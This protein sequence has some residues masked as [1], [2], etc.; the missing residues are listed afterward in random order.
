M[1]NNEELIRTIRATLDRERP[2]ST[3]EAQKIIERLQTAHNRRKIES[4]DGLSPEQ[5]AGFLYMPFECP[6]FVTFALQL[7]AYA[8]APILELYGRIANA[9][10][11][12]GLKTTVKGNLPRALVREAAFACFPEDPD[13][14]RHVFS[15]EDFP[16][17]HGVRLMT[18]LA[19]LIRKQHGKF[20]LTAKARK[21]HA[22]GGVASSFAE[23]FRTF[24]KQFHWGYWD[25]LPEL[26]IVQDAFMFSL[27]LFAR[28]GAEPR[29]ESFYSDAFL[30]AFPLAIREAVE[31]PW[32]TPEETVRMTY[33]IRTFRFM[34]L[35]GFAERLD[36]Q[37]E[38]QRRLYSPTRV[39][40]VRKLPLLD[41][42]LR[43][44]V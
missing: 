22:S 32:R 15:E 41:A 6:Q 23:L 5:M 18:G 42:W 4:F 38:T 35:L 26:P 8:Q 27:L 13:I 9:I 12:K 31:S 28:Y 36:E 29:P 14:E 16:F 19:G 11:E 20:L 1:P 37:K 25:G 34:E 17:L 3:E 40:Q 2:A 44:T 21:L 33:E 10:G 43:F 24:A 7:P 39:G 30:R